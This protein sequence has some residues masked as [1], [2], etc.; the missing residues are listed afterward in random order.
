MRDMTMN[1]S[2]KSLFLSSVLLVL[3][4]SEATLN[5]LHLSDLSIEVTH[6]C[7]TI[8][9]CLLNTKIITRVALTAV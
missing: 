5:Q 2:S 9:T 7:I 8:I 4:E 6:F 3:A 1:D